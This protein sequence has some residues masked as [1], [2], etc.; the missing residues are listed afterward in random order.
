MKA[1]GRMARTGSKRRRERKE[2]EE[3]LLRE[4]AER[5]VTGAWKDPLSAE[6]P[7]AVTCAKAENFEMP[8][9]V[10]MRAV[11]EAR[12]ATH[13]RQLAFTEHCKQK[14]FA[15]QCIG[16]STE[17]GAIIALIVMVLLC[18]CCCRG[19]RRRHNHWD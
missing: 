16:T 17:S 11:A 19:D 3:Q 13:A 2:R 4:R 15:L 7:S 8:I 9:C 6:E 10:Q 14:P 5:H 12:A 18:F 1:A